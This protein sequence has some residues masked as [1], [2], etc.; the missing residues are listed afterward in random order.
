MQN[1]T[2]KILKILNMIVIFNSCLIILYLVLKLT[3]TFFEIRSLLEIPFSF[4]LFL[5][6]PLMSYPAIISIFRAC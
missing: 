2:L 1:L 6:L 4:Y 5:I 3:E